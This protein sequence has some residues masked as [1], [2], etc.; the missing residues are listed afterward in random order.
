MP[1]KP[2]ADDDDED[3]NICWGTGSIG[4]LRDGAPRGLRITH[5]I[6]FVH[7]PERVEKR[8]KATKPKSAKR[9]KRTR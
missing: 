6:G 5:P 7:F 1:R 2:R 3:V 8:T 9:R 4:D